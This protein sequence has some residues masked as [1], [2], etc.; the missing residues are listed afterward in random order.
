VFNK[1]YSAFIVIAGNIMQVCMECDSPVEISL[2]HKP[3]LKNS[4]STYCCT[5]D[6]KQFYIKV[7]L[8]MTRTV[9]DIS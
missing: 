6:W 1:L 3:P 7:C 2:S 9:I 8:Y 4:E 5:I